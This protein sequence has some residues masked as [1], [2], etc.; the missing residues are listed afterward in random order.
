MKRLGAAALWLVA[1]QPAEPVAPMVLDLPE[2]IA[3][4]VGSDQI[5]VETVSRIASAE[6]V[7]PRVARDRAVYDALFAEEG[8][9]RLDPAT[10]RAGTRAVEARALLEQLAAQARAGGPPSDAELDVLLRERWLEFDRPEAVVVVHAV[11]LTPAG[12]KTEAAEKV[13]KELK[14][15]LAG[16]TDP[17][18]FLRV[19]QEIPNG[20]ITIRAE[21][22][23][24]ICADT[25]GF[26]LGIAGAQSAGNF[27]SEFTRAAHALKQPGDQSPLVHTGFGYHVILLEER[28]PERRV[29]REEARQQLFGDA[30]ARR[31]DREKRGLVERLQAAGRIEV[32]RNF[33]ALTAGLGPPP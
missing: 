1:C 27:D 6:Q 32:S 13:G 4:R 14:E 9:A 8:R 2:G 16:I 19:A 33:D 23:P 30:V 11:A 18:E 5:R 10:V 21:R 22:V 24:A 20:E 29:A 26:H 12:G 28:L 25:R 31:A 7:E 3:A 17:N 15:K